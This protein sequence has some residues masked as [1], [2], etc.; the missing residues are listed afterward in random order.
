MRFKLKEVQVPP[1]ALAVVMYVLIQGPTGRA[2]SS[3]C[4]PG[5]VQVDPVGFDIELHLLDLP[6]LDQS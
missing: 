2:S 1:A 6:W 4:T 5:D 3:A